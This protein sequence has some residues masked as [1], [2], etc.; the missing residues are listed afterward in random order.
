MV[1]PQ[2]LVLLSGP[3]AVGKTTLRQALLSEHGFVYVRSSGYLR[4]LLEDRGKIET[5]TTLQNLGD[6]LDRQTNYRWLLDDVATPALAASPAQ[7]R[8]LVDAVRKH[9]QVEHFR[10]AYGAS[11]L[12]VH[13]R[14]D[15]AVLRLR[16]SQRGD[17]TSYDVA[18]QH[19]N[20]V[21]AR[22]LIDIA[23]LV[24]DTGS[25]SAERAAD[26]VAK[27]AARRDRAWP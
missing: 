1:V 7:R 6:E 14:A 3:V 18:I 17:A 22:S 20:E 15:E 19:E 23:D 25:G 13:L 10:A 8:W 11:V 5:R 2:T 4:Q 16:Y 27:V 12:H 26:Q 9:R 21:A 24:I